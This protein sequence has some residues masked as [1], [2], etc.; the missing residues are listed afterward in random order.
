MKKFIKVV[1][2]VMATLMMMSIIPITA[3]AASKKAVKVS[4]ASSGVKISWKKTSKAGK[5]KVYRSTSKNKGYKVVATTSK[6]TY[7]DKKAKAGKTYYYTVKTTKKTKA[8]YAKSKIMRLTAPVLKSIVAKEVG[9]EVVV[10]W[11]SVKGAKKYNVYYSIVKNGKTTYDSYETVKTTSLTTILDKAGTYKFKVVAV[12]GSYKSSNSNV[13]SLNFVK[14]P[15]IAI[16]VGETTDKVKEVV[17]LLNAFAESF[18]MTLDIKVT[19]ED[20]EIV[21]IDEKCRVTGLKPGDTKIVLKITSEIAG[22]KSTTTEK[23]WIRVKGEITKDQ[24]AELVKKKFSGDYAYI[25]AEKTV[26]I[27]GV[28][29]YEIDVKYLNSAGT[30]STVT[31]YYVS[32]DGKKVVEKYD[33][34]SYVGD[35]VNSNGGI[36]RVNSDHTYEMIT[37]NQVVSGRYDLGITDTEKV[38]RLILFPQL[39]V[40]EENGVATT[41]PAP[42]GEYEATI[43]DNKLTTAMESMD[44]VYTKK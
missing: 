12:N 27:D 19:A 35:Y 40:T 2:A 36:F 9:N 26:T 16:K 25:P 29:Y 37:S 5:Y 39:I 34:P 18:E 22:E 30:Y 7:T 8:S 44:I 33:I 23:I 32:V 10:K 41:T 28:K 43:K 21:S 38:V 6:L 3:S 24:A 4:N 14:T 11:S 17:D 13:K 42:D 20:P 1:S 15:D 31:I